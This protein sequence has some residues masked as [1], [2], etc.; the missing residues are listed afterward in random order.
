MEDRLV[1]AEKYRNKSEEL[2]TIAATLKSV[3]A[4]RMFLEM[5]ADYINMAEMLERGAKQTPGGR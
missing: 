4:Q 5:A 3:A 1:R 2:C